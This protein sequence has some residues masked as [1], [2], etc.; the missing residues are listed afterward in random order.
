MKVCVILVS[1]V[2]LAPSAFGFVTFGT[3]WGPMGPGVATHLAGHEGTPG[4]VSWS[5]MSGGIPITGF[6]EA[7]DSHDG[8]LT[9]E[10]GGLLG[11]PFSLAEEIAAIDAAFDTWAAV[12]GLTVIGP[13]PDSGAPGGG[14]MGSGAHIAD[15]RIAVISGFASS[16]V[17]A[18]AYSPG[19]EALYGAG[20][21]IMGDVHFNAEKDWVDDADD[22]DDGAFYDLQ[23]VALHEIG[24]SLGL[25]HSDVAGSVMDASYEGGKRELT[26]DDIAGI[27]FIYGP[28]PEPASMVALGL[29][30]FAL[31][32]RRRRRN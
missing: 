29:G 12:C 23:T 5:I 22:L 1:A 27:S 26:A 8:E 14:P 30:V 18:H 10:L 11:S 20:G 9:G 4:V 3:K 24:H 13:I 16:S 17:L 25:L 31:V 7:P 15:I 32:V 19:T 21:T 28:V 6:P 2:A